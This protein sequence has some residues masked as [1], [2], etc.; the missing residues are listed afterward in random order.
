M[1]LCVC[2][3]V[4]ARPVAG[5]GSGLAVMRAGTV[6]AMAFGMRWHEGRHGACDAAQ[7][8]LPVPSLH[9]HGQGDAHTHP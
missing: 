2:H 3:A 8:L 5:C 9:T 1:H 4:K 7:L 6:P